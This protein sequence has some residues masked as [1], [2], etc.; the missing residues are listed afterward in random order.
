LIVNDPTALIA[1][2]ELLAGLGILVVGINFYLSVGRYF[3]HRLISPNEPYKF[4]SG[5]P[6][7][8]VAFLWP[9]TAMFWWAGYPRWAILAFVL[10]LIDPLGPIAF[11]ISFFRSARR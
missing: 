4:V 7:L 11:V 10:S 8:G 5:L 9:A 6:I 1:I 2:A 3:L